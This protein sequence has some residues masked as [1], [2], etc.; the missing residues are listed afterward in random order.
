MKNFILLFLF[1][2]FT[3]ADGFA[4]SQQKIGVDT[5]KIGNSD[6][7]YDPTIEL[8]GTNVKIKASKSTGKAQFT[9]DGTVW[10][11][12]GSGSGSGDGGISILENGSFEDGL[13]P[14]WTHS[15]GTFSHETYT[16]GLEGELKFARFVSTTS[17]QYF[18]T[19]LKAI[20][21]FANGGCL[22]KINYNTADTSNWKLQVYD[23]SAN[24]LKEENLYVKNWQ[25]GHASFPC[26]VGGTQIKARV[27]SLG[28]GQI[29]ADK[30]YLGKEN[31]TFQMAQ[32]K[33]AGE[34]YFAGVPG[35][36]L[37]RTSTTLGALTPVSA[38]PSPVI[39]NSSMGQWQTT[40]AN[41]VRQTINNLPAGT[42]KARFF[43]GVYAN[44]TNR[45]IFAIHDG[46]TTCNPVYGESG[47]PQS[48]VVVECIFSYA[49]TGSRAFE[50]YAASTGGTLQLTNDNDTPPVGSKFIL[51]YYPNET[52]TALI[53]EAQNWFIDVNIGG[54]NPTS[55][56][57]A[58]Y[59]EYQHASLDMVPNTGSA[60][61]KIPCSSTNPSTGW[62]C[63]AGNESVGVVFTPP[64]AG[65]YEACIY[66]SSSV[67]AGWTLAVQLV[68][69][70][71]ASNTILQE[72]K[73]RIALQN[74][75]AAQMYGNISHCGTFYFS[76]VTERA[77]RLMNE[78][79]T[80]LNLLLG[81]RSA[82]NGQRDIRIIIRPLLS[83]YNRF[84]LTGNEITTKGVNN[85][86]F[87][88]VSY[89][90][91]ATTA[92]IVNGACAFMDQIGNTVSSI[93]RTAQG[94]YSMVLGK[95]YSKIKCSLTAVSGTA[96]G[97]ATLTNPSAYNTNTVTFSNGLQG[98]SAY[99]SYGTLHC[100]AIP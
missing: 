50:L 96:N 30:G 44:S 6:S 33:I 99:D 74:G 72:G 66:G 70:A 58:S 15:G 32:A 16:N 59:T 9:N 67:Q 97:G 73:T 68:E 83:A 85:P 26:P 11:N 49:S 61:A 100:H 18:E 55:T 34:S 82:S 91:T 77:I 14:G 80:A 5:L 64:E 87:F 40:D 94:S 62:T 3:L 84:H 92:C 46:T 13:T 31:R 90:A 88:S 57:S 42:Y 69:T 10:K 56:N 25:D 19:T 36:V 28:A 75:N 89:G 47:T 37:S 54:A 86:E 4:Q 22:A 60:A 29:E 98:T 24:L 27:I 45:N 23:S 65:F 20:P 21:D 43:I 12:L 76:S 48:G 93:S 8:Q 79:D 53:P 81:D 71:S 1:T 78:S 63:S 95:V 52:Q 2:I 7:V 51:E 39:V 35:C 17:G 38:C 41:L